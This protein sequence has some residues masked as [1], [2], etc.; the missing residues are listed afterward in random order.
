[1]RTIIGS[2]YDPIRQPNRVTKEEFVL[3]KTYIWQQKAWPKFTL[4]HS[5]ILSHLSRA[6]K[7]QGKILAQAA[8]LGLETQ[9]QILTEDALTTSAIE[10]EKLDVQSIRS[11][12]ARRLGL[13]T[14]GLPT[15]QRNVEDLVEMLIDATKNYTKPLSASRL[16]GWQAGLFPTGYAGI[17]KIAV[18]DWRDSSEPMR[19]VSGQMGK[20]KV[21]FEA[22]PS[23]LVA[24][25]MKKFLEWFNAKNEIDGLLRAAVAHFWFVT[26]HPFDDGNGRLAR[27]ISDLAL[28][29]DEALSKRFYSLSSQISQDRDAYY[30]ILERTQKGTLDITEWVIWFLK[31]FVRAIERSQTYIERALT[32]GNFW[33]THSQVELNSRQK[34]VLAK[35]LE[36]EPKGFEGGI[37][38]RKYVSLTKASSASAKRDLV[39]LEAKGLLK[40]NKSQGRSISYS[41]V[42]KI[43]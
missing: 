6:R 38:N 40:R 13:S 15:Q 7:A 33:K 34:K 42:L 17:H 14:A 43:K 12:V 30:E 10:G 4:K 22:P 2:I 5:E 20:E 18:G 37:T 26:I 3:A 11:S 35:M 32:V 29:Q 9:A 27:A 36:A 19:V 23:A 41:L 24:A 39:D 21:H 31:T 8:H 1:M 25:E 28:A 16:K